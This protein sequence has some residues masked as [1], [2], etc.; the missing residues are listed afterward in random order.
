MYNLGILYF[1]LYTINLM[2]D[3][4]DNILVSSLQSSHS[5]LWIYWH[6]NGNSGG[7]E[8]CSYKASSLLR[9]YCENM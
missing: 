8:I 7:V 5:L 4:F 9:A 1:L 6:E 3:L 2:S